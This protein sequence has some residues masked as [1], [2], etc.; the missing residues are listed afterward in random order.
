MK[1]GPETSTVAQVV[2]VEVDEETGEVNVKRVT[3]AHNTGT[4]LNPLTHQ[5]QIDGAVVMG[6]GYGTME[7]IITDD[8]GKV[9]TANL[10]D[11]K[12]PNIKDIP[13]LKTAIFQSDAGSGPYNSMSIGETAII[14]TAAAIANAVEDAIGARV[15]SLPITAEKVLAAIKQRWI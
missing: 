6:L 8:G 10:G 2:E 5:G 9:L 15:M 14:P 7:Q 12:I 11:Y 13:Q 1:E 4:I 3:T